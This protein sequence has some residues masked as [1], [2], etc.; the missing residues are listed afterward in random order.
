MNYEVNR[1]PTQNNV[2]QDDL[3]GLQLRRVGDRTVADRPAF[4]DATGAE[5]PE[6]KQVPVKMFPLAP[7]SDRFG[8]LSIMTDKKKEV[9]LLASI[10]VLDAESKAAAEADLDTRF[11]APLITG[12]NRVWVKNGNRYFDTITEVG[13]RI[14]LVRDPEAHFAWSDPQRTQ[15]TIKDSAGNRYRLNVN[16]LAEADRIKLMTAL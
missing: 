1:M 4:T 11:Q 9:A 12:F 13:E 7:L 3:H 8:P 2:Y 16:S 15:A 6:L 5:Q 10:H 14:F